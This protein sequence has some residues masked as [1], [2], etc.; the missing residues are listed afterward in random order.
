MEKSNLEER[1][2]EESESSAG[3]DSSQKQATQEQQHSS[4]MSILEAPKLGRGRPWIY[5]S[6][7]DIEEAIR[8]RRDKQQARMERLHNQRRF[9]GEVNLPKIL[10]N[11]A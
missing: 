10:P 1:N 2:S 8:V 7:E 4:R 5:T 9:S 3:V 6:E 11:Y